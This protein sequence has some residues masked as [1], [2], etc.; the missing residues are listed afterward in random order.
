MKA[1][2]EVVS[3]HNNSLTIIKLKLEKQ[4]QEQEMQ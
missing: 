3:F 4:K 1:E 2:Y